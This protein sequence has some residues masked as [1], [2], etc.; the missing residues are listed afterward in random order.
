M[1][2]IHHAAICVSDI[3][4]SLRFWRDG[5]GFAPLMDAS[6]DGDWDTLFSADS[7]RL[8]SVFLGD[9]ADESVGI[10]ELVSFGTVPARVPKAD[11]PD[12]GF[13]LLSV[14]CDVDATL[15][16]LA[17]LGLGGEPRRITAYGVAM[18]VV[19]EPSGMRVE[20]IDL[21][22]GEADRAARVT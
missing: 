16:R 8:R 15:A 9:P 13:F 19:R 14:N 20:L 4:A 18:V 12:E 6:F 17:A 10:V 5:L 7:H 3:D 11:V 1:A 22:S 2:K 21:P